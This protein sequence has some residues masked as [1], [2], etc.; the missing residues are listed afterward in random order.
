MP[1]K[2]A[3]RTPIPFT[4]EQEADHARLGYQ[5]WPLKFTYEEDVPPIVA[6]MDEENGLYAIYSANGVRLS[7][8]LVL[9]TSE[10]LQKEQAQGN[11]KP[12]PTLKDSIQQDINAGDYLLT[13]NYDQNSL[14][15]NLVFRNLNV[16]TVAHQLT[17]ER[18]WADSV[19]KRNPE[20][21]LKLPKELIDGGAILNEVWEKRFAR[22]QQETVSNQR[23]L[24]VYFTVDEIAAANSE[25]GF[26][27][28]FNSKGELI[29]GWIDCAINP[30]TEKEVK[31]GT[32]KRKKAVDSLDTP[33]TDALGAELSVDDWVFSNDNHYNTFMLCQVLGFTDEKVHLLGYSKYR[34]SMDGH[35][36]TTWN[37]SK[38]IVKLPIEII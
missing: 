1:I 35:R 14:E 9:K 34:N 32:Y 21:T 22:R 8:W 20:A 13:H 16:K 2:Y 24:S 38:K 7:D 12:G 26:F 36:I 33:V 23:I 27:G 5:R 3:V 28:Y 19:R 25:E 11:A 31:E 29:S 6:E 17:N 37:N 15:L 4:E 18:S 30:W 10:S